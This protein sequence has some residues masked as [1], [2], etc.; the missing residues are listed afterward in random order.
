[1][2]VNQQET[3]N[4]NYFFHHYFSRKRKMQATKNMLPVGERKAPDSSW[5]ECQG[6]SY[7]FCICY[8]F[9]QILQLMSMTE[10]CEITKLKQRLGQKILQI[11]LKLVGPDEFHP[12]LIATAS[13]LFKHKSSKCNLAQLL[14]C[15]MEPRDHTW[16]PG[17][18]Q[19]Q[20]RSLKGKKGGARDYR[21]FSLTSIPGKILVQTIKLW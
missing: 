11:V 2:G 3:L 7:L 14:G 17:K 10:G 8:H 15:F 13:Q 12:W 6:A 9:R 18:V 1:M 16:K 19:T 21:L 4:D 20:F 5:L